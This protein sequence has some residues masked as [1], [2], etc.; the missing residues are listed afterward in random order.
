MQQ[1]GATLPQRVGGAIRVIKQQL[2]CCHDDGVTVF[3]EHLQPQS[4]VPGGAMGACYDVAQLENGDVMIAAEYGL[5][6]L[7][8]SGEPLL[9][10]NNVHA[11]T[12]V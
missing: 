8:T 11:C 7:D 4:K 3:D 5:Y 2:W 9:T 10:M 12:R 1:R 6:V